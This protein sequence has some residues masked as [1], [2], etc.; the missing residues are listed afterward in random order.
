MIYLELWGRSCVCQRRKW[1][2][3]RTRGRPPIWQHV[4]WRWPF[5]R[6]RPSN[7]WWCCRGMLWK[8]RRKLLE[9][10]ISDILQFS[11]RRK[12]LDRYHITRDWPR[13]PFFRTQLMALVMFLWKKVTEKFTAIS[14]VMPSLIWCYLLILAKLTLT[15]TT[16]PITLNLPADLLTHLDLLAPIKEQKSLMSQEKCRPFIFALQNEYLWINKILLPFT[17]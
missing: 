6:W 11:V 14:L 12:L 9:C 10:R 17:K 1:Y 4:G 7:G 16:M 2:K 15:L 8:Y 3:V 13:K 5:R